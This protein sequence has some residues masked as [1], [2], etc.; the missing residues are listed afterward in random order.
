MKWIINFFT[1]SLGRKL[2]MSLTGLFLILFLIVHLTGNIKLLADDGGKSFT[3]FVVFM[4]HNPLVKI[5]AWGLYLFILLHAIQGT[6]IWITN[7][8]TKGK[9]YAVN[10][11]ANAT[12]ASKN[13]FYLGVLIFVFL[14]I[15]MGDWWLELKM[16]KQYD[17]AALYQNVIDTFKIPAYVI[18]YD[19]SMIALFFHLH[20]GFQSAFQ[21][22]GLNHKKY[23]PLIKGLGWIYSILV[24][25]GFF[26][27][28][29]YIYFFK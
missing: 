17:D 28:P 13:M 1:S 5:T 9:G 15:H 4:E 25:L 22:L 26:L 29:I 20:H 23:T 16:L 27:I 24:P 6:I 10:T 8:R 2:I 11:L 14:V 21:T 19:L 3:D 18:I 7:R 12:W